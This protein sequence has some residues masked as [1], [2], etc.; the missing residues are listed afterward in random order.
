MKVIIY[1][2]NFRMYLSPSENVRNLTL[3]RQF[4]TLA[5]FAVQV[6]GR[7]MCDSFVYIKHAIMPIAFTK[8]PKVFHSKKMIGALEKER[9]KKPYTYM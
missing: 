1:A 3:E 9:R 7:N 4:I 5:N 2:I 6:T 8:S